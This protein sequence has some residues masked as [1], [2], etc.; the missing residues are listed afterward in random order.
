M[1]RTS[2][3]DVSHDPDRIQTWIPD[4]NLTV[5][6]IEAPHSSGDVRWT[7]QFPKRTRCE[8]P[9]HHSTRRFGRL[10][11]GYIR[12]LCACF[13]RHGLSRD[14]HG[15][16]RRLTGGARQL[17][18]QRGVSPRIE[19]GEASPQLPEAAIWAAKPTKILGC[20]KLRTRRQTI[21]TR[22][23][24]GEGGLCSS[25]LRAGFDSPPAGRT[26]NWGF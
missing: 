14:E 16:C 15:S 4:R 11:R 5:P 22:L 6:S 12:R 20:R 3:E 17:E 25:A 21:A 8:P 18:G 24:W 7:T 13:R 19:P 10:D 1:S 23:V 26:G 9:T 2:T